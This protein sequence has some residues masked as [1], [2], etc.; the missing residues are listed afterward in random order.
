VAGDCAGPASDEFPA[1]VGP[2]P[3]GPER[4]GDLEAGTEGQGGTDTRRVARGPVGRHWDLEGDTGTRM[5]PRAKVAQRPGW[6]VA[7]GPEE[8]H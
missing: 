6:R 3:R 2:G 5:A 4:H 7:G 8:W 1:F